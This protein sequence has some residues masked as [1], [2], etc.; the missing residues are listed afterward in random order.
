MTVLF[1]TLALG[2]GIGALA[3]FAFAGTAPD[4]WVAILIAWLGGAVLSLSFAGLGARL[5]P[6][7]QAAGDCSHTAR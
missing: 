4:P 7:T 2:Y 3:G 5:P 1:R 6:A